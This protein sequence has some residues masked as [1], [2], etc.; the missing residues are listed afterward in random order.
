MQLNAETR[1]QDLADAYPWLIEKV[2]SMDPRLK[3]ANTMIGRALIKKSTIQDVS[4]L[5][6]YA[7]DQ[8][9]PELQKLL[10]E[11]ERQG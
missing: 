2:A 10:D 11:H 9:I 3:V 1:L 4:R 6:G 5:S 7:V 8:I